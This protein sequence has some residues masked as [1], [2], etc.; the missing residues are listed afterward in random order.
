MSNAANNPNTSKL[1]LLPLTVGAG[2]GG[3]TGPAGVGGDVGLIVGGRRLN[4]EELAP[5]VVEE[6]CDDPEEDPFEVEFELEL[7]PV[8][9]MSDTGTSSAETDAVTTPVVI[10]LPAARMSSH[11]ARPAEIVHSAKMTRL[12]VGTTAV[13]KSSVES[14]T[15]VIV[16]GMEAVP[17]TSVPSRTYV[18]PASPVPATDPMKEPLNPGT[19]KEVSAAS[20]T[21]ANTAKASTFLNIVV[22]LEPGGA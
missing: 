18:V 2:P 12:S 14:S 9:L 20:A 22:V 7:E 21:L 1:R 6:A 13:S 11:T 19:S 3:V 17:M 5:D 4:D 16:T 15:T 8:P 10:S